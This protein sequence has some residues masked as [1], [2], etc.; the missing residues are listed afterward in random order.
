MPGTD[1]IRVEDLYLPDRYQARMMVSGR[2]A[3][4]SCSEWFTV[5]VKY[6]DAMGWVKTNRGSFPRTCSSKCAAKGRAARNKTSAVERNRQVQAAAQERAV[7]LRAVLEQARNVCWVCWVY[8]VVDARAGVCEGCL[9][10]IEHSCRGKVRHE[11]P[12]AVAAAGWIEESAGAPMSVYPCGVCGWWHVG[13]PVPAR[14]A[15]RNRFA[16]SM[17]VQR[18]EPRWL[19]RLRVSWFESLSGWK[20]PTRVVR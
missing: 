8:P 13:T 1:L 2:C 14:V 6:K 17:F 20:R 9:T 11:A 4:P 16:A 3:V 19:A 5:L 7:A 15:K 12:A 18:A 10:K